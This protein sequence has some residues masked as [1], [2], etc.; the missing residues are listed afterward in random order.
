M[1]IRILHP[2]YTE[3]LH[4]D[5]LPITFAHLD[6][7]DLLMVERVCKIWHQASISHNELWE[8][9]A[10]N[11]KIFVNRALPI[12]A[13]VIQ[14]FYPYCQA[15]RKVFFNELKAIPKNPYPILEKQMIDNQIANLDKATQD[16]MKEL[17]HFLKV[18]E[19]PLNLVNEGIALIQDS[20]KMIPVWVETG[21][22]K[23]NEDLY[24]HLTNQDNYVQQFRKDIFFLTKTSTHFL[25]KLFDDEV[26]VSK[27]LG[28]QQAMSC[29]KA[30]TIS[31]HS[32]IEYILHFTEKPS[33][34]MIRYLCITSATIQ[35]REKWYEIGLICHNK[36]DNFS[37]LCQDDDWAKAFEQFIVKEGVSVHVKISYPVFIQEILKKMD[38]KEM[39]DL[40]H[41]LVP[42]SVNKT[43]PYVDFMNEQMVKDLQLSLMQK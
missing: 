17:S 26:G 10:S 5:V 37:A 30:M 4:Y 33:L 13:Q 12:R 15:A 29:M 27:I 1:T 38:P 31:I 7:A 2:D 40:I 18:G 24:L 36:K 43:S 6:L 20:I 8:S 9:I 39:L 22:L 23:V 16:P 41:N 35:L 28:F 25:F 3:T 14:S 32:L 42:L 34:P 11:K 19:S 21:L